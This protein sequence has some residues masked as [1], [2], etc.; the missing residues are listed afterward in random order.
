MKSILF[1]TLATIS[2]TLWAADSHKLEQRWL[3][4][5]LRTPES[6]L[7]YKSGGEE[8]LLVSEIEGEGSGVDGKGGVAKL[9]LD[10]KKIDQDWVRGLN[11]PKGMAYHQDLLY[12]AD[13]TEV[14]VIKIATGEIVKKIP[15]ADSVFLNDVTTNSRGEVFVSDSHTHK[16]HR[17]L[18]GEKVETYL[19]N[20]T[21]VNGLTV[22]DDVLIVAADDKLF[23]TQKDKTLKILAEGFAAQADGVE[24]VAPNEYVVSCWVGLIYYVHSDGRIELLIDSREQKINTAD[25]GY[26]TEKR[27]VYVPNFFKDSVTA[28]QLK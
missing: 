20:V 17:I 8:F 12:V 2:S 26:D 10:G 24:L 15:V 18:D 16:V 1:L 3:T 21:K 6:V 28:Y 27:V 14:A 25:I 4:E 5:G 22:V 11:A 7:V 19:E 23:A 13:I 9:A